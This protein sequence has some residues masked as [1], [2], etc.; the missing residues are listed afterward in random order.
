MMNTMI[1]SF[2]RETHR[3][4][5]S[6]SVVLPLIQSVFFL[7][8]NRSVTRYRAR[9]YTSRL[10]KCGTETL[11]SCISEILPV[12]VQETVAE[13][14]SGTLTVHFGNLDSPLKWATAPSKAPL[15]AGLTKNH[16]ME[17]VQLHTFA[18]M[19]DGVVTIVTYKLQ[20]ELLAFTRLQRTRA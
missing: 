12:Y 11:R 8:L 20:P 19:T 13:R 7:L 15:R 16:C 2:P 10:I 5:Q 4:R 18:V 6:I 1:F 14:T 9:P 17:V 3:C